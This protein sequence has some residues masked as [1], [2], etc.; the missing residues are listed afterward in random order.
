MM[1]QKHFL[2]AS[3]IICYHELLKFFTTIKPLL[4]SVALYIL[5]AL[6]VTCHYNY[7][8]A[9]DCKQ[10]FVNSTLQLSRNSLSCFFRLSF[11][12]TKDL[13]CCRTLQI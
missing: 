10:L 7:S 9:E 13:S 8:N 4:H 12:V 2:F 6:T 1:S 5:T 3:N 11:T